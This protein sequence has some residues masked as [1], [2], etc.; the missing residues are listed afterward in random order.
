MSKNLKMRQ[1]VDSSRRAVG[2]RRT[3]D[4]GIAA[5]ALGAKMEV[6]VRRRGRREVG[7]AIWVSYLG[8]SD[9]HAKGVDYSVHKREPRVISEHS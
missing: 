5:K 2:R 4:R 8:W 7:K 3:W 1:N 9:F 6:G